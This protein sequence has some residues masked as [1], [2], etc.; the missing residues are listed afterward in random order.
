[1]HDPGGGVLPGFVG[2]ALVRPAGARAVRV[3]TSEN[4][5]PGIGWLGG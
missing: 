2:R 5:A 1:M 4:C 3:A